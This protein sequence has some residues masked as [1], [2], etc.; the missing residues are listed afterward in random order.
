MLTG[1]V[2]ELYLAD[3]DGGYYFLVVVL[4]LMLRLSDVVVC[5]ATG[6]L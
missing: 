4:V 5:T 2:W 6:E 1:E 3:D